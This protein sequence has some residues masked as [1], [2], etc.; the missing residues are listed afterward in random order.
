MPE[1]WF[2]SRQVSSDQLREC[3]SD[4]RLRWVYAER[5]S[6]VVLDELQEWLAGPVGLENWLHG[7]AFSSEMEIAWWQEE[8]MFSLRA[9]IENGTPPTGPT[10]QPDPGGS[11]L[12]RQSEE[13]MLLFGEYD[14]EKGDIQQPTW[15]TARIPRYLTYPVSGNP[16]E[17]VALKVAY[18][19]FNNM[20]CEQRL[21]EL[22][23]GEA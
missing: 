3:L 11:Q 21:L 7:R 20:R 13:E 12:T 23:K 19:Q 15:S 9:C 16:T 22:S 18:Y 14:P 1:R 6:D 10:W 4:P 2:I 5:V 8:S 17:R